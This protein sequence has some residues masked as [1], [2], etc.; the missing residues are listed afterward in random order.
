MKQAQF[1]LRSYKKLLNYIL[2]SNFYIKGFHN[3]NKYKRVVIMRHD[4]DFCTFSA[5]K[6]AELEN[7]M[8]V[9]STFFFLVN[10]S[11]Y[12]L[13]SQEHYLNVCKIL[14]LGHNIGLHFDTSFYNKKECEKYCKKEIKVLEKLF[15][16]KTNII[17]FHRPTKSFLNLNKK[18]AGYEHTYMKKY[19]K[20]MFYCSDSQGAWL[21]NQPENI[22]KNNLYKS[23]FKIQLL[24]H[25][26]WWNINNYLTPQKKISSFLLKKYE[27]LKQE[28]AKNCKPYRKFK[29]G[30]KN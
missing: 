23:E 8:D 5:L 9:K 1:S 4:I 19:T 17:S 11:F 2:N 28:A 29:Y 30:K 16:I 13:H 20:N 7:K 10:T 27:F 21:Y 12:N 6:I 22:I 18:F 15:G 14:D 25:P 3:F 24:T 26:I